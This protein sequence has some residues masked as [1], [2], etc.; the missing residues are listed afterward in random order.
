M[1]PHASPAACASWTARLQSLRVAD[2]DV[3]DVITDL[4]AMGVLP[5]DAPTPHAIN[6]AIGLILA[7]NAETELRAICEAYGDVEPGHAR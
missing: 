4:R 6:E 3:Q 1:P 2:A 5:A 7:A